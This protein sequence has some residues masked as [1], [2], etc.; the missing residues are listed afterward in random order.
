MEKLISENNLSLEN[1]NQ[2]Q[3]DVYWNQAKT[4]EKQK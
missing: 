2:T 3:M 4:K 1:M